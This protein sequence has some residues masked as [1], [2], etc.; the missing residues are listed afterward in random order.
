MKKTFDRL[1]SI[2]IALILVV[3]L[4]P[5]TAFIAAEDVMAADS[6]SVTVTEGYYSLTLSPFV[7]DITSQNGTSTISTTV[8]YNNRPSN[9][10]D[11]TWSSS[12]TD[13]ATVDG[14]GKVTGLER[15]SVMIT[16]TLTRVG[17]YTLT[18]PISASVKVNIEFS[19]GG[20]PGENNREYPAEGSVKIDKTASSDLMEK[21]GLSKVELDVAGVGL[22]PGVDVVLIVDVSNSMGWSLQNSHNTYDAQR[23][24]TGNQT[25]KL[26][27]AMVAAESFANILLDGNTGTKYDNSVSFVT[28]AG[29]DK[30]FCNTNSNQG[31]NDYNSCRDSVMTV[32]T[33]K[34]SYNEVLNTFENTTIVGTAASNGRS[35]SYQLRIDGDYG[36]HNGNNRG[37]TNYDYAFVQA[38]SAVTAL[39]DNYLDKYGVS[40][41]DSKRETYV[42]FMTD[43]APSHYNNRVAGGDAVTNRD[44]LPNGTN[45]TYYDTEFDT[46]QKWYNYISNNDNSYAVSLYN[47]IGGNLYV[48]GF[49]LAHGGFTA[50][51]GSWQWQENELKTF[52]EGMVNNSTGKTIPVQV[53]AS[54]DEI[55]VFYESLATLIKPA[56]TQ[57]QVI[58]EVNTTDFTVQMASTFLFDA[59]GAN[60]RRPFEERPNMQL[61]AYTL[62][63]ASTCGGDQS[64]IGKRTGAVEILETVT[65]NDEGTQAYSDQICDSN[66]NIMTGSG[67][68]I[69][70]NARYFTFTKDGDNETFVWNIGDIPDK[71]LAFSFYVYLKGSME[72]YRDKGGAL[73]TNNEATL[74]YVDIDGNYVADT[75][76]QPSAVWKDAATQVEFY[77]V[78]EQGEP[79]NH[80]GDKVSFALRVIIG[81][82]DPITFPVNHSQT[83][84]HEL[85]VTAAGYLPEGY[86]LYDRDAKYMVRAV[87]DA[88]LGSLLEISAPSDYARIAPQ[89]G[90]QTTKDVL[91]ELGTYT[92]INRSLKLSTRV[93]F[94]V[95]Y[96]LVPKMQLTKDIAVIDYAK[97]ID[98]DV[99]ANE[100]KIPEGF[101]ASLEGYNPFDATA[102]LTTKYAVNG[103]NALEYD[104]ND[105]PE[106]GSGKFTLNTSKTAHYE[107]TKFINTVDKTFGVVKLVNDANNTDQYY[108]YNEIDVMPANNIYYEDDFVTANNT[109]TTVGFVYT[110]TWTSDGS[111]ANNI[112]TPNNEVHGGWVD[113]D[114]GLSDDTTYSDGL[115]HKSSEVGAKVSFSFNGTGVDIYT[116]TNTD[117]GKVLATLY[118]VDGESKKAVKMKFIDNYADSGDYYQI[119]TLSFS[120]LAYGK[121]EVVLTVRSA[122]KSD[123]SKR[124]E[125]CIDG[126]RVY[127][128]IQNLESDSAVMDAYGE[129]ELGATFTVARDLLQANSAAFIDQVYKLYYKP[130]D[131]EET[132]VTNEGND[133]LF[134]AGGNYDDSMGT[135]VNAVGDPIVD[136]DGRTV[137]VSQKDSGNVDYTVDETL[138]NLV[139]PPNFE[140]GIKSAGYI[141]GDYTSSELGKIAPT[142]EIYLKDGQAICIKPDNNSAKGYYIGIKK[143]D[144]AD[145]TVEI[146]NGASEKKEIIVNHT[147]DLYYKVVPD[148]EGLIFISNAIGSGKIAI[149]KLRVAGASAE[150]EETTQS[151]NPIDISSAPKKLSAFL[152]LPVTIDNESLIEEETIDQGTDFT[153][154]GENDI[155]IENPSDFEE[156][157]EHDDS[158]NVVLE[159]MKHNN[160]MMQNIIKRLVEILFGGIRNMFV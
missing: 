150:T 86:V 14:T 85:E 159:S 69:T 26:R 141:V 120:D 111:A 97:P 152:A 106:D 104:D 57:A 129:A 74:T 42:V 107:L 56:G 126:I 32:F 130:L 149:T 143:L 151:E 62:Y 154:L 15:G 4:L 101:T 58:D 61:K 90:A 114:P 99:L 18:T 91:D 44:K 49:D 102:D 5:A 64:L 73:Y 112:E 77:L 68:N 128:P 76:P 153:D 124:S 110:G 29:Y 31:S 55:R 39:Q 139:V 6:R 9:D 132:Y 41:A 1:L 131:G 38:S 33:G 160:S 93:A 81:V 54:S 118:S 89:N 75:Y 83:D 96:D 27:D 36:D 60:E 25:T 115:A 16:A 12:D 17:R 20:N 121:Y 133:I 66:F 158:S 123:G 100:T 30:E 109:D 125:Y 52:L 11:I 24:P 88:T 157:F 51:G 92:E 22:R 21:N 23:L 138:I 98:I 78:N 40:Y 79:V 45:N 10:Y 127:N 155:V 103:D 94:G 148:D 28:F 50:T 147:T 72:G 3:T 65:F 108:M 34:T 43:G 82:T 95:R 2:M 116:R 84:D 37:N 87:S 137:S 105:V 13:M 47:Q 8:T 67:D 145:A 122:T 146:S 53:T 136:V 70:I 134:A 140:V 156:G 35:A 135:F 142:N 7:T 144:G 46:Q 71:E 117:S 63:N 59:E 119:P 80:A 113:E 48:I 19:L